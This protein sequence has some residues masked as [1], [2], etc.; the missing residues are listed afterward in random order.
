MSGSVLGKI[1]TRIFAGGALRSN[2][3]IKES[4]AKELSISYANKIL[5]AI[6][7]VESNL[8]ADHENMLEHKSQKSA[9]RLFELNEKQANT[10]Y[11]RGVLSLNKLLDTRA[12]TYNSH[13]LFIESERKL[14]QSRLALY[15]SL[16]GDW[17]G[18]NRV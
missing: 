9:L 17:L 14:W 1:T 11:I 13:K 18:E 8:K 12:R 4:R 7:E 15:L 5:S 10:R 6:A 16:G 3:K 2:I